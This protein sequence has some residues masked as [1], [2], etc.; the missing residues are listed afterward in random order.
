MTFY[1]DMAATAADLIA[2]FGQPVT[3]T[4]S[5][6]GTYNT[7][8][9]TNGAP[10]V[11]T[12][13]CLAVEDAYKAREIDGTLIRVGDKKLI[14][15]PQTSAGAS[16]TAPQTGDTVTF[17]DTSVWTVKAVEPLSPGGTALIYTLQLRQG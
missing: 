3:L 11:T 5:V 7:A 14:L 10:Q 16:V 1:A 4:R 2:E 12:Q 17:A 15:S 9:A 13:S 6:P 8:T